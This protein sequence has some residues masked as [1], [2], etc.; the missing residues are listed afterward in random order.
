MKPFV[1]SREALSAAHLP[2]AVRPSDCY[3]AVG[4]F[5]GDRLKVDIRS[6]IDV[7]QVL[8]DPS[9]ESGVAGMAH[10]S[11]VLPGHRVIHQRIRLQP[12]LSALATSAVLSHEVFHILSA[13]HRLRLP[14][15]LEEGAANLMQYLFLRH[16][17]SDEAAAL[18]LALLND[19]DP[20]YGEGFRLARHAY[21]RCG[22]FQAFMDYLRSVESKRA[23]EPSPG[24]PSGG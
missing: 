8:M 6:A 9:L 19:P 17:R 2:G 16:Q 21:K 18:Q 7:E 4:R 3:Q 1:C 14:L 5:Y 24:R 12:G 10:W 23:C 13:M 22:G 15:L 20:I 11:V